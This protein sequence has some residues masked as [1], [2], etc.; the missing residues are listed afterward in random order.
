M[1]YYERKVREKQS[2]N[3]RQKTRACQNDKGERRRLIVDNALECRV[4]ENDKHKARQ[5]EIEHMER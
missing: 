4:K 5:R 1:Q 2:K 3:V